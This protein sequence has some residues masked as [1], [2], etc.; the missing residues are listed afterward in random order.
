[1]RSRYLLLAALG[2]SALMGAAHAT[3][4]R[5]VDTYLSATGSAPAGDFLRPAAVRVLP[6]GPV[7]ATVYYIRDGEP[8]GAVRVVTTIA[9]APDGVPARFVSHL[10]KGERAEV[11]VAGPVGSEPMAVE[12]AYDGDLLK[13]SALTEPQPQS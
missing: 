4:I 10:T 13:V 3:N 5:A 11:S 12:L 8:A 2:A 1:M 9:A 7:T 6:L